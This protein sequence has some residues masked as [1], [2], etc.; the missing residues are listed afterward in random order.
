M[1]GDLGT[2]CYIDGQ[3]ATMPSLG[4]PFFPRRRCYRGGIEGLGKLQ[5]TCPTNVL[6][7]FGGFTVREIGAAVHGADVSA[8][9]AIDRGSHV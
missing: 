6:F 3:F 2:V 1:M 5:S 4:L 7:D 9:G 8:A